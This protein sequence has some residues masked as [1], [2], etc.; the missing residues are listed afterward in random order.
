LGPVAPR[1][2][3][4]RRENATKDRAPD[5]GRSRQQLLERVGR[6]DRVAA[7]AGFGVDADANLD[8][9]VGRLERCAA[10]ATCQAGPRMRLSSLEKLLQRAELAAHVD[11][12]LLMKRSWTMPGLQVRLAM[13]AAYGSTS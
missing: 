8:L 10:R 11:S 1:P 3:D 2:G 6:V 12:G 4:D 13:I 7:P 9:V 5:L